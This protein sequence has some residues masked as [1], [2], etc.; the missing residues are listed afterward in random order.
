M[1]TTHIVSEFHVN[2]GECASET[3]NKNLENYEQEFAGFSC[4]MM[5]SVPEVIRKFLYQ[6]RF[7][8]CVSGLTD[9]FYY[10]TFQLEF[11]LLCKHAKSLQS[12]LTLCDPMDCNPPGFS[13][14]GILQA[15]ILKWI[16]MPSSRGYSIY[17]YL[18]SFK[19]FPYL[20]C[21]ILLSRVPCAIQQVFV[22][23]P[24]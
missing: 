1:Q 12:C 14:H 4:I 6:I 20:G 8:V 22:G 15:R 3:T 13:V 24:F 5:P 9:S 21:C 16:A 17:M 10:F 2:M 18:F 7:L 23:Y 19:F 11:K